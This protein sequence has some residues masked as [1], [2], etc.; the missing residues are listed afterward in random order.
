MTDDVRDFT[1]QTLFAEAKQDLADEEFIAQVMSGTDKLKRRAVIG[2]IFV[3]LVIAL[4]AIPLG[5]TVVLLSQS[6]VSSFIDLDDQL[7]AQI[8]SPLNNVGSLLALG[9]I[10][11]RIVY[12]KIFS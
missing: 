12:R 4:L 6:L 9:L 7:L 3:G 8:L 11:L 10:G 1:L 5:D 2:R